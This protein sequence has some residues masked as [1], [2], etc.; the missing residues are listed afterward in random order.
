MR[1]MDIVFIYRVENR[2][3]KYYF[4]NKYKFKYLVFILIMFY[5]K[6]NIICINMIILFCK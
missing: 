1:Y 4:I 6:N 2:I 5:F 3:K